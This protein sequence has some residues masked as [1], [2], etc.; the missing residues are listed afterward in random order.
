[1]GVLEKRLF[2]FA[3]IGTPDSPATSLVSIK[4]TL[5]HNVLIRSI[6]EDCREREVSCCMKAHVIPI[7]TY[8]TTSPFYL[9]TFFKKFSFFTVI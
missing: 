9:H 1:V 6:T 8:Q 7:K 4:T 3:V 2:F 5:P